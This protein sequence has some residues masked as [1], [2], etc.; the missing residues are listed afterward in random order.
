MEVIMMNRNEKGQFEKGN[1]FKDLTG[2]EFG[3]L[4]VE[5]LSE[6]KAGRKHYWWCVCECGNRKEIRSDCLTRSVKPVRSCGCL[7]DEQAVKNIA[8]NNKHK[9][10]RSHLHYLWSRMKQRCTNPND[11]RYINYGGRGIKV[12]DEWMHDFVA[13]KEWAYNNG[14]RED[15]SIERIDVN[16]DYKPSNCTWIPFTKQA[17]NRTTT[18]WIEYQGE[19]LNLKQWSKKLG[20]NYG[21]LNSRYNRSGMRPP[22]LFKPVEKR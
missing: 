8:K 22:E 20:I 16:D 1:G 7:R 11:P 15:L 19:T 10:S 14:Y 18:I 12:C 4:K 5:G 2:K 21:T 9:D 3:K 6:R 17:I 13:F